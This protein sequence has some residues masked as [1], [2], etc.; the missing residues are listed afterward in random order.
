MYVRALEAGDENVQ[1]DFCALPFFHFIFLNGRL[2][3]QVC[4]YSALPERSGTFCWSLVDQPTYFKSQVLVQG[5]KLGSKEWIWKNKSNWKL[6]EIYKI[7][8]IYCRFSKTL[9]IVWKN[10]KKLEATAGHVK[11]MK[12][13]EDLLTKWNLGPQWSAKQGQNW[14]F[15]ALTPF[16][17]PGCLTPQ[18]VKNLAIIFFFFHFFFILFR[19]PAVASNLVR[20]FQTILGGI[21]YDQIHTYVITWSWQIHHFQNSW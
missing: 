14:K 11:G 19:C 8:F 18:Y 5:Y 3:H 7:D 15:S 16:G 20:F 9:N 1:V 6:F 4:M 10:L 2:A 12:I 21:K 13:N 17:T